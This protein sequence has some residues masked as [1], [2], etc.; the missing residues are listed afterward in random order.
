MKDEEDEREIQQ[1]QQQQQQQIHSDAVKNAI[2][3]VDKILEKLGPSQQQT[4]N[5]GGM[6]CSDAQSIVK[7]LTSIVRKLKRAKCNCCSMFMMCGC[8]Q[9][10]HGNQQSNMKMFPYSQDI[11]ANIRPFATLAMISPKAFQNAL[12]PEASSRG[13]LQTQT[14]SIGTQSVG[15]QSVGTQDYQQQQQQQSNLRGGQLDPNQHE[16]LDP[17]QRDNSENGH[18]LLQPRDGDQERND[19]QTTAQSYTAE[20]EYESS[21]QT[22]EM[23][24]L[25]K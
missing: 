12:Q 24:L 5:Q 10:Q 2:S 22:T 9:Q 6:C 8:C 14:N 3:E 1:Q 15:T 13:N 16:M 25:N 20:A 7:L 11:P 17:E 23:L 18:L 4:T 19:G 21:G